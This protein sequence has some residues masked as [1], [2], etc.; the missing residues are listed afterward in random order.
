MFY[1][2]A[3]RPKTEPIVLKE[4]KVVIHRLPDKVV[5]Q[6]LHRTITP[7][8]KEVYL[9]GQKVTVIMPES[10]Y[11]KTPEKVVMNMVIM[12]IMHTRGVLH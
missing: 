5:N 6:Y 7:K 2:S 10:K 4:F 3:K 11:L 1:V 12:V 8:K 9:Q